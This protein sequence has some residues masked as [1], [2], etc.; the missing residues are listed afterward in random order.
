MPTAP[1]KGRPLV[2]RVSRRVLWA[3]TAAIPLHNIA[4]VDAFQLKPDWGAAFLRILKWLVGAF[5]V[6]AAIYYG[7]DGEARL[8]DGGSP[9]VVVL[10][11]GL[12]VTMTELFSSRKPVLIVEMNSGSR[13]ITTLP[14]VE[15]L[16]AIAGRIVD[17]IDNPAAEFT[18]V[19]QQYNS[20][21]TNNYGPVV[22]M[23]GGRENTGFKL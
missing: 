18:A 5:L 22:N 21:Q 2:L 1:H 15:E 9:A 8:G 17:A 19:V 23:T 4:W 14:T 7:S 16:R 13:V 10:V 12:V 3:G 11:I 6:Y 20:R